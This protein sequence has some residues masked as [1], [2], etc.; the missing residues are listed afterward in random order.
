M[1]RVI[2]AISLVF[3]LVFPAFNLPY[4]NTF[5]VILFMYILLAESYDLLAG[6]TGYVNMGHIAFFGLGAYTFGI[7][8]NKGVPLYLSCVGGVLV[9]VIFAVLISFPFLESM[10]SEHPTPQ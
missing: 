3:L 4:I 6:Y 9:A 5:L 1:N 2:I 8:W 7:L 10:A